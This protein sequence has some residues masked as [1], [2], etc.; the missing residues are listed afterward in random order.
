MKTKGGAGEGAG[1]THLGLDLW[2]EM[3]NE[4]SGRVEMGG[5]MRSREKE[6]PQLSTAPLSVLARVPRDGDPVP[7][8]TTSVPL[9]K[10]PDHK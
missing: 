4:S 10:V 9:S 5:R 3:K 6:R 8:R 2:G 1:W 7:V